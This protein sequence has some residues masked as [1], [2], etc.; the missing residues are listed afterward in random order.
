MKNNKNKSSKDDKKEKA[1]VRINLEDP[2][3]FEYLDLLVK[4]A[5]IKMDTDENLMQG[6]ISGTYWADSLA[7]KITQESGDL[8]NVRNESNSISII[9]DRGTANDSDIA[10][11]LSDIS[12][13]YKMKGGSGVNF[14]LVGVKAIDNA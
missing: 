2:Q 7:D 13:L 5:K 6:S 11:I 14:E 4:T 10:D 1:T 9:L 8:V 3:T 12:L